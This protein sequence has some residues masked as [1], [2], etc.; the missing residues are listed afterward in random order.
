M[1]QYQTITI[2]R[3]ATFSYLGTISLPAG[4]WTAQ[5]QIR[6]AAGELVDSFV[7]VITPPLAPSV[8]H[9][10]SLYVPASSTV[11]WPIAT[12]LSDIKFTDAAGFVLYGE[13]FAITIEKAETS[14]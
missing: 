3:G 8:L 1:K 9:G 13:T 14:V 5:A 4:V 2:K 6:N 12:L 11:T 10:I 7:V